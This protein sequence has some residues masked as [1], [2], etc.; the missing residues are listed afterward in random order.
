M[1]KIVHRFVD[2]SG[3]SFLDEI[4]FP[5]SMTI[6]HVE[7]AD[8]YHV[9]TT[10]STNVNLIA[11]FIRE[12]NEDVLDGNVLLTTGDPTCN[13]FE[14]QKLRVRQLLF[15]NTIGWR[16]GLRDINRFDHVTFYVSR[17]LQNIKTF[18]KEEI[19]KLSPSANLERS[20][21]SIYENLFNEELYAKISSYM[22]AHP[23]WKRC[24]WIAGMEPLTV[25][26]IV[27]T[28]VDP[29]KYVTFDENNKLS[30]I[31][32]KKV[33]IAPPIVT[34]KKIAAIELINNVFVS[35]YNCFAKAVNN[36]DEITND[37][38]LDPSM[39]FLRHGYRCAIEELGSEATSFERI[40]RTI[41]RFREKLSNFI[42]LNW[43]TTSY[44]N[45][46]PPFDPV[47]FFNEEEDV[48]DS[49]YSAAAS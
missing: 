39:F 15:E 40:Q 34:D 5:A 10:H 1:Q 47:K 30:S 22:S 46:F 4:S 16:G 8:K 33:C 32:F 38:L 48:I 29:A 7:P 9:F 19:G 43:L 25:F 13:D 26:V 11:E 44:V 27:G 49:Y 23:L 35:I 14:S 20:V 2:P 37:S 6:A 42:W 28:L 12:Y 24:S 18:V 17:E 31:E 3:R 36:V 41:L 45:S 21:I